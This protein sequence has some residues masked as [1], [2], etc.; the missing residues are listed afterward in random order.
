MR[1]SWTR[2]YHSTLSPLTSVKAPFGTLLGTT[3]GG[4]HVYS[5][6]YT[7]LDPAVRSNRTHFQSLLGDVTTGYKWQCVELGRRYLLVNHGVVFDNIAMAYDIFRLKCVTRV[8]DGKLLPLHAHANGT[9]S[10]RPTKGSLLI[11]TP[12]GEF[13]QTGHVA[14]IVDV[15]LSYVDI[16]EQNVHDAVWPSQR[17]YSRRLPLH[18]DPN[19]NTYA[20]SCTY[21]DGNILGWMTVDLD[22]EYNYE[23][24]HPFTASDLVRPSSAHPHEFRMPPSGAAALEHATN[25]LH[26]MMLDATDYMLQHSER[27]V[28]S[29]DVPERLWSPLRKSWFEQKP[30]DLVSQFEFTLTDDGLHWTGYS[31]NTLP[32]YVATSPDSTVEATLIQAWRAKAITTPLHLLK[33]CLAHEELARSTAHAAGLVCHSLSSLNDLVPAKG[34]GFLDPDGRPVRTLWHASPWPTL[35]R[36][37]HP[38]LL[39]PS[40]RWIEPLWTTLSNSSAIAPLL[41]D[42]YP[43]HPMLQ[44]APPVAGVR[45][46]TWAVKGQFA[47]A[48]VQAKASTLPLHVITSP[49]HDQP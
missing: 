2:M 9:S 17:S 47:A 3:D 34:G 28:G 37:N 36:H 13:R 19:T 14:V 4:V 40:I 5:S 38:A 1:A 31:S 25:Q 44:P 30:D 45:L 48:A 46:I 6:D 27:F 22:N 18:Y 32:D 43:H 15:G 23:D 21:A 10:T 41:R 16:V 35:L 7:T 12:S 11:W 49:L 39:C 8:A 29:T 33:D 24:L 42:L 26:H 20:I